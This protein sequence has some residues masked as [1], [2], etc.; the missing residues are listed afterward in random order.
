MEALFIHRVSLTI[1]KFLFWLYWRKILIH[2]GAFALVLFTVLT[3]ESP[4]Y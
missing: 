1:T 4:G 3:L 2:S